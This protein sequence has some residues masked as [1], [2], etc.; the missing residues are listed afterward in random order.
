MPKE[1]VRNRG[2]EPETDQSPAAQTAVQISWSKEHQYVQIGIV[3]LT[4]P[5]VEGMVTPKSRERLDAWVEEFLDDANDA[6]IDFEALSQ[7]VPGVHRGWFIQADRSALN[8]M[9]RILRRA[10]DGAFGRDE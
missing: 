9:I 2:F 10:R 6:T 5:E 3:D 4:A 1:I 8:A 7:M